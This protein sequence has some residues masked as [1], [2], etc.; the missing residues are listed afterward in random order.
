[1]ITL[2]TLVITMIVILLAAIIMLNTT[3]RHRLLVVTELGRHGGLHIAQCFDSPG[4]CLFNGPV[5]HIV[6]IPDT[7]P[8]L[9]IMRNM[10]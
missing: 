9:P 3:V 6:D 10:P 8:A 1:M 7:N 2:V 5:W 4:T